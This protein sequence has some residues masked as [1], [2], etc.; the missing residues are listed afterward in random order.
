MRRNAGNAWPLWR[1]RNLGT[2]KRFY[3]EGVDRLTDNGPARSLCYRASAGAS[4]APYALASFLTRSTVPIP[5]P[6]IAA[7]FLIPT[8]LRSDWTIA[9]S[10]ASSTFGRPRTLPC[11]RA[12]VSPAWMR[13][14]MILRSNWA[15][16]PQT[17]KINFPISVEVSMF[18]WSMNRSH[19][20]ASRCLIVPSRSINDDPTD[21]TDSDVVAVDVVPLH[22]RLGF[23]LG[24][25]RVP[26]SWDHAKGPGLRP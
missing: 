10:V 5:Q 8:P 21:K 13:C 9:D 3:C 26:G 22:C 12:R 19:P 6:S 14:W 11:A 20:T 18:C 1:T 25:T 16:A 17:L 4:E 24:L 2:R 7:V 23:R 15:K